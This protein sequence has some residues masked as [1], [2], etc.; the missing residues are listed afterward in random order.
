MADVAPATSQKFIE[1]ILILVGGA[2][3]SK[4]LCEVV[5]H[6]TTLV[7]HFEAK[8]ANVVARVQVG[9]CETNTHTN[10]G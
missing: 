7:D 5:T 2:Q 4:V 3:G 1:E 9:H 6:S 10:S 8:G